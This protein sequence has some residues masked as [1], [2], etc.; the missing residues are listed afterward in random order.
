MGVEVLDRIDVP[1]GEPSYRAQAER[2]ADLNPD[3][4][5]VQAGSVESAALIQGAAEAGASLH[6]IGETG[7]IQPEFIQ[8]LG[9]EP[10]ASQKS[11]GYAAFTYNDE[12]PAWE[13][14]QP[15]W[16]GTEGYGRGVE[17]TDDGLDP[18]TG[19]YHYTT[20]DV[21]VHTAL[22]VEYGGSYRAS[23]WAPAMFAV[24]DPPGE[25]CYTYQ[26]CLDL[27]R[28]GEDI[29]YEGVTG[30]GAYSPGGVNVLKQAY[31]PFNADGTP[32]TPAVIEA[33]RAI[34]VIELI[35]VSAECETPQPPGGEPA[36]KGCEW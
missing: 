7:W 14:Y 12:T 1:A 15:L 31:T 10:L 11:I 25:V 29:D 2:I 9:L 34:E 23:D 24:G 26:T 16:D 35:A 3:A 17:W 21:L 8:T 33:D 27:I 18:A 28:A 22:A 32:G 13:F 4:V 5:I 6:W 20:Y 30:P 19:N 36:A